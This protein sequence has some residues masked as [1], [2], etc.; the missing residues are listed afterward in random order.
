[1]DTRKD[2]K[3]ARSRRRRERRAVQRSNAVETSNPIKPSQ[4]GIGAVS[5]HETSGEEAQK[6]PK[7]PSIIPKTTP[8]Q[9][10]KEE[11]EH[12]KPDQTPWWKM[13]LEAAAVAVGIVVAIIYGLQLGQ[14]IDSNK[15][16]RESLESVQRAFIV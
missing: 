12:C 1:M 11:T 7:N 6:S 14:M 13:F 8:P 3:R 4:Q 5:P 2:R 15:L 16:S 10:K 9:K